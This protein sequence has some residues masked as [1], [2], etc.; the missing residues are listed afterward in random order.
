MA[1]FEFKGIDVGSGKTV[2][3]YRDAENQK[4]LRGMLRKDGIMLTLATEEAAR[5][6]RAKK[7][8]DLFAVFRR[9]TTADVAVMT[10][11]LSTLVR[12]E[13]LSSSRSMRSPSRSKKRRSCACSPASARA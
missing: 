8:I 13:C 1:V 7:E 3:G 10:R 6:A 12:A 11:Q 9:V 5:K 4:V 2:K